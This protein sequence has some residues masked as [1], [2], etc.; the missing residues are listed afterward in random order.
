MS[1]ISVYKQRS[2]TSPARVLTTLTRQ[3]ALDSFE[4][5][6]LVIA[7]APIPSFINNTIVTFMKDWH[8]N[9]T[10]VLATPLGTITSQL[11]LDSFQIGN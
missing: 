1:K 6:E 11:A 5:G 7:N 2:R 3:M 8:T 4:V 10:R 9:N